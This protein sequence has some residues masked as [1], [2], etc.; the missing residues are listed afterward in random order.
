MVKQALKILGEKVDPNNQLYFVVVA[1]LN[2]KKSLK[3]TNF[4][5]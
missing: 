3:A 1:C 5:F 4:F 2:Q